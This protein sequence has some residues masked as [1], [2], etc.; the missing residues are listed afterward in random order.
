[1]YNAYVSLFWL[2]PGVV[3]GGVPAVVEEPPAVRAARRPRAPRAA[4]GEAEARANRHQLLERAV[5]RDQRGHAA[6]HRLHHRQPVALRP[7]RVHQHVR[8]RV[9][10]RQLAYGYRYATLTHNIIYTQP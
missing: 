4:G 1:M 3:G 2:T 9:Q 6:R 5:V 7:R 10:A 8:R